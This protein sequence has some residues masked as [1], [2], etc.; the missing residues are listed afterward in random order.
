MT[1]VDPAT[2]RALAA[3]LVALIASRVI[4]LVVSAR[5]TRRLAARG[6]VQHGARHFPLL[7]AIHVLF[8]LALIAEVVGLGARPWASWPLWLAL[9][10]AAQ[11]L[12]A[13][14]IHALGERWTA[15]IW[16]LPGEPLVRRGVY[17]WMRHPNYLA[18]VIE[19]AAG[20]LLFGAWRTTLVISALDALGLAIR[21]RAENRALRSAAPREGSGPVPSL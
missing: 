8:P 12:R 10:L 16:V 21:I 4:E 13:A 19:L 7:V 18:V 20:P 17:R 1:A 2:T 5:H 15:G 14:S 3:F 6:A 9:W 11:A